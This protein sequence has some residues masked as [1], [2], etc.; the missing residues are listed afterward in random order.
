MLNE[1]KMS[2]R[3]GIVVVVAVVVVN[4]VL[5]STKKELDCE[6]I[7]SVRF[8]PKS[9]NKGCINQMS[10]GQLIWSVSFI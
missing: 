7:N 9:W 8:W 1:S 6:H 2:R 10:N 4:V 5:M 3:T